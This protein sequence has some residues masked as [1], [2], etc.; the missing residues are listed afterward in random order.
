MSA[1]SQVHRVSEHQPSVVHPQPIEPPAPDVLRVALGIPVSKE[2]SAAC[3]GRGSSQ[4]QSWQRKV[5]TSEPRAK[6]R[7]SGESSWS[8]RGRLEV[9]DAEYRPCVIIGGGIAG[10]AAAAELERAG[11]DFVLL[12][13]GMSCGRT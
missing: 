13:A 1:Q 7:N 8:R 9:D 3:N 11:L 12:E 6:S 2:G 10:L 5:S 4:H